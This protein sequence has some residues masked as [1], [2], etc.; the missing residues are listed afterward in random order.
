MNTEIEAKNK[1]W[2]RYYN[3]YEPTIL[4]R[5]MYAT[6]RAVLKKVLSYAPRDISILDVG[7]GQGSTLQSFRD[8]GFKN[9]QGIELSDAGLMRCQLR[10]FEMGR[11]VHKM[12]GTATPFPDRSWEVVF[13]EGTLEHYEDF[14][15]FVKEWT[16]I[17]DQYIIIVQP[18]HAALYS[19]IIQWGWERFRSD[20]GGVK[21]LTYK[22]SDFVYHFGKHG[23][24]LKSA[25]FTPLRENAVM[26]FG[27]ANP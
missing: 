4:G 20:A 1:L 19:R 25:W 22:L 2:D 12:D 6:H 13:S 8:W 10:G 15:P 23:F 21:E 26:I 17:A 24:R 27:R 11:D 14:T 7:C 16:R 18:N 5:I 9:S 3:E